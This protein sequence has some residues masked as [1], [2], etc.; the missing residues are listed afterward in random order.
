MGWRAGGILLVGTDFLFFL[1]WP[2]GGGGRGRVHQSQIPKNS[3]KL[4]CLASCLQPAAETGAGLLEGVAEPE[5]VLF[6]DGD[7]TKG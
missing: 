2:L 7:I 5:S 6:Q 1:T 3:K 4:V